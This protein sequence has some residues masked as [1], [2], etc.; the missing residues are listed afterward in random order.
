LTV[1]ASERARRI[2]VWFTDKDSPLPMVS[3]RSIFAG[4]LYALSCYKAGL[5]VKIDLPEI[6]DIINTGLGIT[7]AFNLSLFNSDEDLHQSFQRSLDILREKYGV[8]KPETR[9]AASGIRH[10]RSELIAIGAWRLLCSGLT[11]KQAM[12]YMAN[13]SDSVLISAHPS[14]WTRALKSAQ[15]VIPQQYHY[16]T[17]LTDKKS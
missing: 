1:P 11:R 12:V 13:H 3:L 15:N 4:H 8:P 5:P 16:L 14:A 6:G 9:G 10:L 2:R 7:A 17:R